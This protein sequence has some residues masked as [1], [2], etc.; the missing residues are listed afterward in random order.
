MPVPAYSLAGMQA[1][2]KRAEELV[3]VGNLS[4]PLVADKKGRAPVTFGRRYRVGFRRFEVNFQ[5]FPTGSPDDRSRLRIASALL[6]SP[7]ATSTARRA[8]VLLSSP[9]QPSRDLAAG[10]CRRSSVQRDTRARLR[11]L[12]SA[13]HVLREVRI[14]K[15]TLAS[16]GSCLGKILD[17]RLA[18]RRSR[19][20][21]RDGRGTKP[22]RKR[23]R[24]PAWP[25][26]AARCVAHIVLELGVEAQHLA[27]A[28]LRSSDSL[29]E[30]SRSRLQLPGAPIDLR[31]HG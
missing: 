11:V 5:A 12:D 16:E 6:P 24:A 1:R 17:Q 3:G 8:F 26:P 30:L 14:R 23:S 27:L 18:D 10:H 2:L 13:G 7:T 21:A 9:N 4:R 20:T 22:S 15:V 25:S 19:A 31:Q 29:L 28:R